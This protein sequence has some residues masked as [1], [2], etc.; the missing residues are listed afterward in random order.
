[1]QP[2]ACDHPLAQLWGK[3]SGREAPVSK[4][5]FRQAFRKLTAC[6]RTDAFPHEF[7]VEINWYI[8]ESHHRFARSERRSQAQPHLS[9]SNAKA[10]CARGASDT[11]KAPS[12]REGAIQHNGCQGYSPSGLS[13]SEGSGSMG[14]SSEWWARSLPLGAW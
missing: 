14:A 13:T 2:S 12:Q 10:P 1:M 4:V 3:V 7:K 8:P 5:P 11:K 6:L 9:P